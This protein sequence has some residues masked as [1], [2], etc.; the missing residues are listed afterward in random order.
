MASTLHLKAG[1]NKHGEEYGEGFQEFYHVNL[2]E[3]SLGLLN[4]E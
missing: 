1:I 3:L 2:R 4:V